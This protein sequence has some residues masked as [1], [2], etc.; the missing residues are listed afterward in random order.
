MTSD[1][2]SYGQLFLTLL[3]GLCAGFIDSIAGGGGLITV[4]FFT[5]FFGPG[6]HA[7]GTN[8]MSATVGATM[9]LAVYFRKG[10]MDAK[11]S[12]IFAF[13]V[14]LGSLLGSR[15]APLVPLQA[16]K[17]FLV[18]SCP[19]IL[20]IVWNKDLWVDQE[21]KAHTHPNR[22][23]HF[24]GE[25][26]VILSG[27]LCG[28][29]DGI[30]GPGGGTFMFLSLLFFAKLPLFAA[31]A[32]SK[33]ANSCSAL[34]AVIS[35]ASGGYV[36][37]AEGAAMACGVGVGAFCGAQFATKRATRVIRPVLAI[38]AGLL[39]LKLFY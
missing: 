17:W 19:L 21:L 35:Y 13:W 4:P 26:K 29:Y 6:P 23:W 24:L 38:V 30:W 37:F 22:K 12:W 15:T 28:F 33:L 34:V 27:L 32:A 8:K 18:V 39:V 5:L 9:A 1:L 31:I 20:W 7:I 2:A 10:H 3:T 16:F 25:P 36:H 14:G 11:R